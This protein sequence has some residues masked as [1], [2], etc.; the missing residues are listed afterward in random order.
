MSTPASPHDRFFK[1][2]FSRPEAAADLMRH[3]LPPEVVATLDLATLTLAKG[4]FVDSRLKEHHS[5]LLFEVASH[6]GTPVLVYLLVEHKSYPDP[7]VGLD[8]LR[9]AVAIWRDWLNRTGAGKKARLPPLIP[10][11]LYHGAEDWTTP[12]D[13]GELIEAAPTL[14]RYRLQFRHEL[15]NL[16]AVADDHLPAGVVSR[17][18]LLALKYVFRPEIRERIGEIL[19][20]LRHL[21]QEPGGLDYLRTLLNY[22]ISAARE[23]EAEG[24]QAAIET[25]FQAGDEMMPTIAEQWL[26][27]GV[28]R[29]MQQGMQQGIQQG[30][31]RGRREGEGV[32]V[33]RLLRHRFGPLPTWAAERLT[34]AEPDVLEQWAERLLDAPTLEAVFRE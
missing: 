3:A 32:V 22:L 17:A 24:L 18:A 9:Y 6:D 4:S 8:L 12:E 5:D 13:L 20:T 25:H 29:G 31:Q 34:E 11:V 23:L 7:W 19:G 28:Q 15:L 14:A 16:N 1:A 2:S 33:E 30:M 10:L 26:Q 21:E 27:E